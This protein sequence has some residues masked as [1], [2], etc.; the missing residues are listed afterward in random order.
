MLNNKPLQS[1]V[2]ILNPSA[3][4]PGLE[5]SDG[6][7][8]LG[9]LLRR[10]LPA[11]IAIWQS[12]ISVLLAF[13]LART[14][15]FKAT[16]L[17]EAAYFS[18]SILVEMATRI[19]GLL[20][21]V[22]VALLVGYGWSRLRWADFAPDQSMR[23]FI[24]AVA[25]TLAWTFSVYD[26]NFYYGQSHLIERLLLVGL[27][28][29]GMWRPV[30][31][32][33]F[34]A[35]VYLITHQFDQPLACTWTDKR[36]LFDVLSLFVG[37]MLVRLWRPRNWPAVTAGDFFFLAICLQAANYFIPGF[38]KLIA[39]WAVVERLDNLFI[40]SYLN[41]W[42]GFL[43]ESDALGWARLI[44]DWN[45]LMVWGSLLLEL[46]GLVCFLNR[47]FC[48]AF[49]IGCA[50]LHG[51]ICLT[52]GIL[53][54][55]WIILDFSLVAVLALGQHSVVGNLFTTARFWLS[56]GIIAVS[57]FVFSPPWLAWYDTELNEQYHLEVVTNS[58][59]TYQLPRTFMVPYEVYFAQNKFHF[60]TR[61]KYVNGRYGTTSSWEVCR[62]LDGQPSPETAETVREELGEIEYSEQKV[63]A[64]DRFIKSY[65]ANLNHRGKQEGIIPRFLQPPQHIYSVV[66]EPRYAMQG[67]VA[68]V[69]VIH[70]RS[71]YQRD[72]IE[73]LKREV[74]REIKIP[75]L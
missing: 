4:L 12:S 44:A 30:L 39:G 28:F 8:W 67:E 19:P 46:A 40:A 70:E 61:D 68:A 52:T 29:G 37:W 57:H 14:L 25:G 50:G 2:A 22:A 59:E 63:A 17:P 7:S 27:F 26:F 48:I 6:S 54:W 31:M 62:R 51:M 3:A 36:A 23:L 38:G 72:R 43:S 74:V 71:L 73:T 16:K 34:L 24:G 33:P 42:F 64:F 75:S 11:D 53:F 35:L 66:P 5:A 60:L 10:F 47:R 32:A 45:P 21:V 56:V 69:R 41:G 58:G 15:L 18:S 13:A 9:N 65:F 49:L 55:K 20:V 1:S